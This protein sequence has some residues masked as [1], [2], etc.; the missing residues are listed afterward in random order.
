MTRKVKVLVWLLSGLCFWIFLPGSA[1]AVTLNVN[2]NAQAGQLHTIAGALKLLNPSGPNTINV[3]GSCNE[4]VLIQSFQNLTLNAISGASITDAS[5]GAGFVVDIEDSTEV[6]LQGFTINGGDI[7]VF[8]G[9]LSVCRFKNNTIQNA[10]ASVSGDGIGVQVGR[11]RASF[12]GDVVQ[13][14]SVRGVNVANG[15]TAYGFNIQVNNNGFDGINIV[16]GSLFFGDPVSIQNNGTFGVNVA[17]HSTFTLFAGAITGNGSGVTVRGAAEANFE[18]FDG[19]INISGNGGNGV[20][21]HDLSFALFVNGAPGTPLTIKGNNAPFDVNC[22][23]LPFSAQ[24][25]TTNIGGGTTNWTEP[26]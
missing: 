13:H 9:D 5:G 22:L 21:I 20:Q 7:G 8:C 14:N 4:N 18:S 19:P 11:S 25:A 17:N 23:Q 15:S 10:T 12:N 1:Q 16:G 2:C 24:G 3:S 26:Q 6:T